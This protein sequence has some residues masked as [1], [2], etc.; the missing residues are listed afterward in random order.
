MKQKTKKVFSC[1][2]L[3]LYFIALYFMLDYTTE[4]PVWILLT[5]FASVLFM[6]ATHELGHLI[7][8]LLTG[9]QFVSYRIFSLTLIKENG[10]LRLC[11]M[12]VPGTG[13]QC[14]MA[15][16]KKQNGKYPFILYNLGGILL[17]GF[18]SL[19]PIVLS[20]PLFS[21]RPVLGMCLFLFGFMSF[22]LNLLNAIP[23]NGKS[24]INDATNLRLS[25]K[26]PV[27]QDALW[28]QLAYWALHAQNIR[29][30]DMPEEMFFLPEP[31]DLGNILLIWQAVAAVERE[32][33]LGNY[34]KAREY[35]YYVLDRAPFLH[36]LY[37]SV[38][39]AEAVFLDSLLGYD[40]ARID[41]F[42]EKIKKIKA[43]QKTASFQRASYAYFALYKKD[44]EKA[45][46]AFDCFQKTLKK[47]PLPADLHF[48]QRQLKHILT[49]ESV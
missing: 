26:N 24:M 11:R 23:T 46:Q 39:Q 19:I 38:L 13:G 35:V 8:G 21:V 36:P 49:E 18:L 37:E 10:K 6:I 47:I 12:S 43:F 9:Y 29:T 41:V 17:C 16:P 30:G 27:A 20:F 31:K 28:N 4:H 14:L 15:P 1:L 33:D 44:T 7:F 40:S 34:E 5:A 45:R 32:E 25:I 42:Y 48:E 3:S 2:L 22:A